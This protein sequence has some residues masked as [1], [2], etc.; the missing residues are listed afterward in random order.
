MDWTYWDEIHAEPDQKKRLTSA[1]KAECTPVSVDKKHS[2]GVFSGTHGVY[3]T[4][5]DNCTCVDFSRR[6][7]PCKHMYRLAIELGVC[8]DQEGVKNDPFSRKMPMAELKQLTIDL[9]GRIENCS[10]NEQLELKNI[11]LECLYQKKDSLFFEDSSNIEHLLCSGVLD[12]TPC[13][14]HFMLRLTKKDMLTVI[15]SQGDELPADCKLK[16]DI[17][18]W[19]ISHANKYGPLLFKHCMEVKPSQDLLRVGLSVY[20]YLHRKFDEDAHKEYFFDPDIGEM[21]WIE[22]GFPDDFETGLLN[23]FGTNPLGELQTESKINNRNSC[24][25]QI[26]F[27]A[28]AE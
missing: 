3:H 16:A 21:N 26:K 2:T 15:E 17:A 10:E 8:A 7:K 9:V 27:E 22:K 25:I 24:T 28:T 12:G 20:K 18:E 13:Y 14:A 1:K 11:L 4:S 19:M 5:L 23:M 6:T